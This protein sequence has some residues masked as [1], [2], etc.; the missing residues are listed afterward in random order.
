MVAAHLRRRR[1]GGGLEARVGV[2]P[3]D[4]AALPLVGDLAPAGERREAQSK[5]VEIALV[6]ARQDADHR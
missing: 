4:L 5:K 3:H 6:P 1:R 2:G